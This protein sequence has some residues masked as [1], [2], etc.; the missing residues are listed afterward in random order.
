M[1]RGLIFTQALSRKFRKRT[2][3]LLGGKTYPEVG[4]ARKL[5][6]KPVEGQAK[7][8]AVPHRLQDGTTKINHCAAGRGY[9]TRMAAA[10][11]KH[12][13]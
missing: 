2:I 7:K 10:L 5:R 6:S 12:A 8:H 9:Q 3:C 11:E 1:V 13:R 4:C